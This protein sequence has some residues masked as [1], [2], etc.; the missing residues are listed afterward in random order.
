MCLSR[1]VEDIGVL[2]LCRLVY[3]YDE[4]PL[5]G[6]VMMYIIILYIICSLFKEFATDRGIYFLL[7]FSKMRPKFIIQSLVKNQRVY[8]AQAY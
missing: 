7:T 2:V 5:T 3:S 1:E 6:L 8:E 4:V